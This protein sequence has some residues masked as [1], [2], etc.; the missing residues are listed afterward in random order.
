MPKIS[1]VVPVRNEEK[2]I[3]KLVETIDLRLNKAKLSYEVIVVDDH[4]SD[5]TALFSNQLSKKYP[6]R[7]V[8]K[9]G[10]P[11]KG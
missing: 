2:N 11:G 5:K 6:L 1:I 10:K 3:K 8:L 4:S 7:Y 9:S